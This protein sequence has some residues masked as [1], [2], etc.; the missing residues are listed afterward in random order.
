[1]PLDDG[2]PWD[3]VYPSVGYYIWTGK[4]LHYLRTNC[5]VC[6]DPNLVLLMAF[7]ATNIALAI[8]KIKLFADFYGGINVSM[9]FFVLFLEIIS[10]LRK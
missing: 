3:A 10:N 2:N 4:L 9:A 5:S 7:N 6:T 1:M 8:W